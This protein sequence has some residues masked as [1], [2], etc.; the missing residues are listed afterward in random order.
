METSVN[1]DPDLALAPEYLFVYGTLRKGAAAPMYRVLARHCEFF[2]DGFINGRLYEVNGYPGLVL[3]GS[4]QEI[5]RG[6][7][8]RIV[9]P[10]TVLPLLDDYEECSDAYPEPREYCRRQLP[11]ALDEGFEVSAWVYIYNH[12][13]S[14]L[15]EIPNGDYLGYL[16]NGS[17]TARKI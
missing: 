3:S 9:N 14:A 13:V 16:Q 7:L 15:T 11:V 4:G 1:S 2:A 8:Y 6:E 5:V 10:E 12:D 17:S